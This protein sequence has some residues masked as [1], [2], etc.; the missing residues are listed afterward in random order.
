MVDECALSVHLGEKFGNLRFRLFLGGEPAAGRGSDC[1]AGPAVTNCVQ[2]QRPHFDCGLDLSIAVLVKGIA[3]L[4]RGENLV[5]GVVIPAVQKYKRLRELHKKAVEA[6]LW[7]P[8]DEIQNIFEGIG[9][10]DTD[11]PVA[12]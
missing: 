7:K 9:P 5:V 10:L 4:L 2:K 3:L 11:A 6:D 1:L 12:K 8:I